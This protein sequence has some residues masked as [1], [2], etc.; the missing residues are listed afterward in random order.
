MKVLVLVNP[1]SGKLAR[2]GPKIIDRIQAFARS[3][4][5]DLQIR[6]SEYPGHCREMARAAADSGKWDR[7]VSC[8]GDGT[9]NEVAGGLV[10]TPQAFGI[11][12]LGTGNGLARHLGIPLALEKAM[13][14]IANP[15][16]ITIDTGTANEKFFCNAAGMGFDAFTGRAYNAIKKRSQW[17]YLRTTLR[18]LWQFRPQTFYFGKKDPEAREIKGH[19]LTVANG[20]Q[21]GMNAR[22]APRAS[23]QDG[24]RDIVGVTVPNLLAVAPLALRLFRGT[25]QRSARVFYEQSGGIHISHTGSHFFHVDG[26]IFPYQDEVHFICHPQSLY[27]CTGEGEV[28]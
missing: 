27:I 11:L 16:I 10:H 24:K 1:H 19:L 22:I 8:G 23:V 21:Y 12:P 3:A 5:W 20:S 13:A 25:L 6:S 9:L 14:V 2:N 15:R 26:E 28:N 7:V 4:D 18:C 17:A